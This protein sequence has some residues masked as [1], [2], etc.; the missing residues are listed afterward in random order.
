MPC[1]DGV[2]I[3]N[4]SNDSFENARRLMVEDQ[5]VGRG[6]RDSRV[7]D[8]MRSVPRELFVP[9]N[10]QYAAYDDGPLPIGEGQT[11]SQPYIVAFMAEALELGPTDR[12]LEIGT[13]S[14]YGAAVLARIAAHVVTV[15]R[16][17]TLARRAR[18]VLA[19]AGLDNITVVA[20]DGSLGAPEHAPYD[21][22]V[23]TAGGPAVPEALKDQLVAGGRLVMPVG[24]SRSTQDLIRLRRG[25]D[26][27]KQEWL[28]PVRFVPLIGKDGWHS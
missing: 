10:L 7:L 9:P 24:E 2:T 15:E 6:I 12:V 17:E 18:D 21:A 20:G 5:I 28:A 23:V 26:G 16:F 13:G 25:D 22:I 19:Q 14:G 27:F 11:I 4:S 8:A 3:M 1:L